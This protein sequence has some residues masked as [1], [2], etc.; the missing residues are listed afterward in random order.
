MF[1]FSLLTMK[2]P[3]STN[4]KPKTNM[5]KQTKNKNPKPSST[6]KPTKKSNVSPYFTISYTN[7]RGLRR[8][9][10][11]VAAHLME[12][13]PDFMAISETGS[14]IPREEFQIQGYSDLISKADPLNRH[15][16]GLGVYIKDGIPCGRVTAYEDPDLPFMCFRV[17]LVHST[18]FIF[19]LYRPQKDGSILFDRIAE[20]IDSIMVD[21]PYANIHVCGDFNVHHKEWLCSNHTSEEGKQCHEFS[22]IYG[23]TQIVKGPTR[24]PDVKGQTANLLDLFLTTV[25]DKCDSTTSSPLG[26]SDHSVVIVKIDATC[27]G[28][29]DVPFHRTVFRY[30][31]ADWD[32][33]RLF[34]A[35]APISSFFKNKPTKI[36]KLLTEW[37]HAGMESFIP[38][39]KYQQRPNSQ[40]WFTPECAAAIAHR[41]HF[42]HLYHKD[43]FNE[44]AEANFKAARSHC[45]RIL[46]N[47]TDTYAQS[48]QEKIGN[49]RVGSREFWRITNNVLNRGKATIP[50]IINGP[51]VISSSIDK[52]NLFASNFASNSTLE[53][54]GHPL[55]EFPSRTDSLLGNITVTVKDIATRIRNLDSTKATGPDD[56]PVIVLKNICPEISPLLAKLFNRCLK[57]RCF[58]DS[59]KMSSVCPVFKNAGDRCSPSQYR[60]I[61]L[62][63]VMSKLFESVIN[64]A[65]ISH[66]DRHKLLS[67]NQYGFR[68]SRSTADI[69]TVITHRVSEALDHGRETRTVALDISKAFDR[70]WHKGLL[71]KLSSYGISGDVLGIIESF[72][73]DRSLRVVVNGQT[74]EAHKINAG[75]PQ[76]SLLGPTLFLLF[77]ND[78]PDHII[79]SFVDIYADDTTMYG[80]TADDLSDSDLAAGLSADLEQVV[81]WGKAWQVTFNSSKTKLLSFHHHREPVFH[82]VQMEG[83]NLVEAPCLE[84]LLGLKLTPDLKWNAYILAVAA[85]TGKMVGSFYRSRK[86][87]TPSAL[88]YLYKSQ[89]RPRM[90]YCCHIWAGAA[91]TTLSSLDRVQRRLRWLVGDDLYGK[92]QPLSLR[93]D[94]AS[95][96]LFYRYYHGMCSE[97]LHSIVPPL[98]TFERTTRFSA[99]IQVNHPYYIDA[100]RAKNNFHGDSFIPRAAALWN[101]LPLDCFPEKCDLD[102]FKKKV[103]VYLSH[104]L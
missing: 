4:Q 89:I 23:L 30:S 82:P 40:P 99:T 25:P 60:P 72:L 103:N 10:P 100:P 55:P 24:V 44:T 43:R 54:R 57:E 93:R 95:L 90:E 85:D 87:L 51:E 12:I 88:L 70:V 37:I 104:L 66:L 86:Y 61:S 33:L 14:C 2:F 22:T 92:L 53:E 21:Y 29:N 56:I 41:N 98:K 77:I 6:R 79:S 69:L 5:T 46:R 13:K 28:S 80:C 68:S 83:S 26:S 39:K 47:A 50:T 17:A 84:K 81:Q 52:A 49:Q 18:S 31:E 97:E 58:P 48:I 7:I 34:I 45:Q 35:D 64:K 78:L 15:G 94:V 16:H 75:V 67:D 42:F 19:T 71:H 59:W 63:S 76:G 36:A 9:L 73:S 11:E 65:V 96:A 32:S 1:C 38:C 102:A 74:S 3:I 62:L 20:K 8:N 27:K 101:S 91:K